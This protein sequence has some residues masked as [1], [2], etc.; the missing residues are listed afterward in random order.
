M[1]GRARSPALRVAVAALVAVALRLGA[2]AHPALA[3]GF[4]LGFARLRGLLGPELVGDCLE[5]EHHNPANGDA[6]QRTTG[7]LLVW[8]KGDNWTAFTDG[9]RT[10]VDGPLG[11]Q[12]RLNT[13]RFAWEGP[14]PP[15]PVGVRALFIARDGAAAVLTVQTAPGGACTL[16]QTPAGGAAPVDLGERTA[17]ASGYAAWSWTAGPR[18][19]A[20]VAT[21]ACGEDSVTEPLDVGT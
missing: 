3:C 4:V 9:Y 16:V 7:G 11:L 2:P 1:V 18:G 13:D 6:L 19:G 17:D 14:P 8:R 5:E 10:W 12:R 15:R 20:G 21:V